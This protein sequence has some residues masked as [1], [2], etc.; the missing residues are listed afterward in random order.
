MLLFQLTK[1]HSQINSS[2]LPVSIG[3]FLSTKAVGKY[4]R[5]DVTHLYKY[6][7]GEALRA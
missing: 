3:Q 6:E 7:E 4:A 2:S 1:R 5:E